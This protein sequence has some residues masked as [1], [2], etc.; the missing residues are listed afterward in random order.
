VDIARLMIKQKR[1]KIFQICKILKVARSN[2]YKHKER[3]LSRYIKP[4][5]ETVKQEVLSVLKERTSY[6]YKRVTALINRERAKNNKPRYNRKRILRVMQLN[7]LM[8][9]S[10]KNRNSRPHTGKV[11][12]M[13]SNIRYCSDI[14]T[15]KCWDGSKVEMAF[16]L[17]CHDR[18]VI[19]HVAHARATNHHDIIKL[20]DYTVMSRFGDN[21]VKLPYEVQFLS[22]LGGP[23]TAYET[24]DYLKSWGFKPINTPAYSPESNGISESFVKRFKDDYVYV[25]ELWTAEAVLRMIPAWVND[26]NENHPHSGLNYLSPREYI[27]LQKVSA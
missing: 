23:Y 24:K 7:N 9:K 18:E 11:I 10:I 27:K 16:S 4:D 25:N 1:F 17:D 15:I 22:D 8:L 21:V 26:Y 2:Q 6:G 14:L 13:G 3:R 5:D 19:A 12:T 20:C